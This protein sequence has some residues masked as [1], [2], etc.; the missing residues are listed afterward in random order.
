VTSLLKRRLACQRAASSTTSVAGRRNRT[1]AEIGRLGLVR[2]S[3][4]EL[5]KG[6]LVAFAQSTEGEAPHPITKKDLG[7][8]SV[9]VPNIR[10]PY[11]CQAVNTQ[12]LN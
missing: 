6:D 2:K 12:R 9:L 8:G 7:S 4:V 10:C 5:A 11:E 3:P 1:P